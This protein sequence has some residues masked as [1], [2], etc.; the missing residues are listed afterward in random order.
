MLSHASTLLDLEGFGG[1]LRYPKNWTQNGN[2]NSE[3]Q[4]LFRFSFPFRGTRTV[5]T[6]LR[7]CLHWDKTGSP[8]SVGNVG[9]I[10]HKQRA[11]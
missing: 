1:L 11:G 6:H 5:T 10:P 8:I 4:R 2:I 7:L 9:E 3:A